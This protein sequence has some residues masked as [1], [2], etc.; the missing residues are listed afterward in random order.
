MGLFAPVLVAGALLFVSPGCS[1]DPEILDPTNV[2]VPPPPP[3]RKNDPGAAPPKGG[4]SPDV[5]PDFY[6]K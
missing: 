5:R 1:K 6:T 2:Q 4:G 3:T